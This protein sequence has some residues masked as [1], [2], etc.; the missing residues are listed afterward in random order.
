MIMNA[1]SRTIKIVSLDF[2]YPSRNNADRPT[3]VLEQ[4][5]ETIPSDLIR[6]MPAKEVV[7]RLCALFIKVPV[8]FAPPG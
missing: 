7:S 5:A 4:P 3:G 8:A 2:L 6:I 1:L